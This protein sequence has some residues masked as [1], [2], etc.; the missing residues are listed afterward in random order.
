M[1]FRSKLAIFVLLTSFYVWR[2]QYTLRNSILTSSPFPD[3]YFHGGNFSSQCETLNDESENNALKFCE[4]V[5]FWDLKDNEANLEERKV[6]FTCDS[7]RKQWNTVMG[8]LHKPEP[9]GSLWLY[10]PNENVATEKPSSLFGFGNTASAS[11]KPQRITLENYPEGHDFHPL[12]VKVWPSYAGN[13]SN[14]FIVNHARQRTFIEQFVISPSS[15]TVATHVRTL[16]SPYFVSPN[17]LALTSPNSFYVSNDHLITRRWPLIGHFVPIM[18][19][20]LGLPLGWVAHVTLDSDATAPFPIQTHAVT[21]PFIPF[22]NGVAISASGAQVAIAST[23]LSQIMMYSRNT[24]TN[25]LVFRESVLVPF[26]PDNI[27]FDDNDSLIVGGHP[28]FL[29]LVKVVK[30]VVPHAPSWVLSI[31]PRASESNLT[32]PPLNYDVMAP[33]PASSRVPATLSSE[34]VTL[35]QSNGVGFSSSTTGLRD[36]TTGALYVPGLYAEEGLLV[37]RPALA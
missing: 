11:I 5:T 20:I 13:S 28:H 17:A 36:S 12:G 21:A 2:S 6:L 19:T 7:G 37:C 27:D 33:I 25:E 32:E 34:V 24:S 23:S 31:T 16:S 30:G 26:C 15:P 10:S 1:A 14:L 18:E 3:G 8:P 35:L 9:H 4:D 29:T 22:P